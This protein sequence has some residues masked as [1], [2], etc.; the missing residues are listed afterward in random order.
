MPAYQQTGT[1]QRIHQDWI[2]IARIVAE[3]DA[4]IFDYEVGNLAEPKWEQRAKMGAYTRQ[5]LDDV[6]KDAATASV[7][8][9][10]SHFVSSFSSSGFCEMRFGAEY[11]VPDHVEEAWEEL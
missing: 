6:A 9:V 2:D 8:F 7:A 3:M 4:S 1:G 10:I 11:A 5:Q